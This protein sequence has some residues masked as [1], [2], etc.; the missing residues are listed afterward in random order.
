MNFIR[1]LLLFCFGFGVCLVKAKGQVNW[2]EP[3][4][5]D[6]IMLVVCCFYI[7]VIENRNEDES[8]SMGISLNIIIMC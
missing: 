8:T 2:R 1:N 5:V 6:D 4:K 3:V 7:L